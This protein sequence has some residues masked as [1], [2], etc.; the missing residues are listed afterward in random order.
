MSFFL[1]KQPV[2]F[3]LFNELHGSLSG[4]VALFKELTENFSNFDE[5]AKRAEAIEHQG[6]ET[7]HKIID[8]LNK[9]F[10][11]PIDREDI[12]QLANEMD[13]IVDLLEDVINNIRLYKITQ[14]LSVFREFAELMRQATGQLSGM[15]ACL[16][17]GKYTKQLAETKIKIHE[18]EDRADKLFE[19][20]IS[21][22]FNNH[23]D[24]IS[25]IKHKDLLEGLEN[26]MDKFQKVTDVIE[27]IIVKLG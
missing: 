10:I 2:F 22:L 1:P 24:P 21:E 19:N 20:S 4:L 14:P 5:F 26:I 15:L 13:D 12:Y 3:K 11:T 9:T 25:V 6:D 27:G 16:E 7:T 23:T 8:T 17:K 18:L